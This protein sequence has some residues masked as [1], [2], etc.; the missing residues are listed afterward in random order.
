[1]SL[2]EKLKNWLDSRWNYQIQCDVFDGLDREEIN[3]IAQKYDISISLSRTEICSKLAKILQDKKEAYKKTLQEDLCANT[4]DPISGTDVQDID[5]RELLTISQN[6]QQY[7]F[8]IEG[9]YKNV[10]VNNNPKNPYT[11]VP[12]DEEAL[13]YIEEEYEKFKLLKGKKFDM[14]VYSSETN[15]GA[16][17]NQLSNYLPY[18]VGIEKFLGANRHTVNNFL[19]ILLEYYNVSI[20]SGWGI[21]PENVVIPVEKDI[22]LREYKITIVRELIKWIVNNDYMNVREAWLDTFQE[23]PSENGLEP[24]LFSAI[25]NNDID[26]IE[27]L[28]DRGV[29]V[30]QHDRLG[31]TPVILAILYKN[32]DIAQLLIQNGADLSIDYNELSPLMIATQTENK[33][34]I[35]LILDNIE[36]IDDRNF[37]NILSMDDIDILQK[38]LSKDIYPDIVVDGDGNTPLHYA[39]INNL[40]TNIIDTLLEEGASV[41]IKNK[42]GSTPLLLAIKDQ[43]PVKLLEMMVKLSDNVEAMNEYGETPLLL[44]EFHNYPSII[45][46]IKEKITFQDREL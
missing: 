34:M 20:P 44:A 25:E 16:M 38:L 10:F 30:N 9:I 14:D 6:D 29:N 24:Q 40:K 4:M 42:E 27:V 45:R 23:T 41:D 2:K 19:N 35:E 26:E 5:S 36:Y 11:N 18:T 15:L 32:L 12:F 33:P 8:E 43:Y 21:F 22:Q 46:L 39:I 17:V 37:K 28:I 31:Y 13:K 3:R 7:C 1:M